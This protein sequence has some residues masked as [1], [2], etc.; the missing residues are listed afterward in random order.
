MN[1]ASERAAWQLS[2]K[3]P[4]TASCLIRPLFSIV[5]RRLPSDQLLRRLKLEPQEMVTNRSFSGPEP[6]ML[7]SPASQ[8]ATARLKP[9]RAVAPPLRSFIRG[10]PI[11]KHRLSPLERSMRILSVA[12]IT[13][14]FVAV[15]ACAHVQA[16]TELTQQI[17]E[18]L[19]RQSWVAWQHHDGAFYQ[20]FLSDDH[21]EVHR[22]G[23]AGKTQIVPFVA[24]SACS[25]ASYTLG[26]M[27]FSQ[28][29]PDAAV[30]TYRAE[31]DTTCGDFTSAEPDMGDLRLCL[32]RW[33]LAKCHL[34]ANA[35]G[36]RSSLVLG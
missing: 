2:R 5:D 14:T 7:P 18:D 12:A 3:E 29:S 4:R 22:T 15:N 11:A 35:R 13:L 19:E 26:E 24:S 6:A 28:F 33:P 10:E 36:C 27:R 32:P 34:R 20:R 8:T 25:V 21:V 17:V 9:N 31:Q 16:Q 1:L 23:L 30:V